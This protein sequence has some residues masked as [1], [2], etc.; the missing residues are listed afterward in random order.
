MIITERLVLRLFVPDDIPALFSILSDKEVNRFLPW[1]PAESLDDAAAFYESRYK[2]HDNSY[3]ICLKEENVPIGYIGIADDEAHDLGY[4]LR[5]EYWHR[6]IAREAATAMLKEA[7]SIG[8]P[9]V[10]ATHD[11]ANERSGNVL[12]SMWER[13][14]SFI[15]KAGTVILLSTIVIWFTTYFGFV[16]GQFRMLEDMEI[17]HSILAGIGN[18][19]A[20]IFTPL[21]WSDLAPADAWKSA[22]AAIT[23]LVAKEN[24][25][26]TFGILYGF[27]EVAEDGAEIWGNL[28]GSMTPVAAYS[29][30]VF[31]LL[32][33]PCFAAMGAIKREM[34]NAKWFWF[35]IGY[36]C[37]LAYVVSLCIYQIGML[38]TTGAFGIGTAAAFLLLAGFL[39]LL[40]R[41][42]KESKTLRVN[43]RKLAGAK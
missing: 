35:A 26:G 24:V 8:L 14:W 18:A 30:L 21:G 28:A 40:F 23:G 9:F 16:D 38:I 6:G 11:I 3:A 42:Y 22:V 19:I 17:D 43:T 5:K 37:G 25:V 33:A 12:R 20:W 2:D 36:Q 27:A 39:Y 1:F 10:S 7:E 29:F 32:C 4:G 34:N 41:P 13:G 15:K 31:N